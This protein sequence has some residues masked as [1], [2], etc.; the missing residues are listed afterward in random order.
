MGY[1]PSLR[2]RWLDIGFFFFVCVFLHGRAER[3]WRS[4]DNHAR[5]NS[6]SRRDM[7]AI[8][9][10]LRYPAWLCALMELQCWAQ[11]LE[12]LPFPQFIVVEIGVPRLCWYLQHW[13]GVGGK[14]PRQY[15]HDGQGI[16]ITLLAL[17]MICF[18]KNKTNWD[19]ITVGAKKCREATLKCVIYC[20]HVVIQTMT[21][22]WKR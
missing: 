21:R 6:W 13:T 7:I 11:V 2:L 18:V 3:Q 22:P 5:H 4:M 8:S 19:Q 17:V 20:L 10:L 9:C 15:V 12:N 14:F 16:R 1:W